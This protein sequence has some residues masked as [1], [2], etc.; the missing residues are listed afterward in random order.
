MNNLGCR[1]PGDVVC[2]PAAA[3]PPITFNYCVL[4][5]ENKNLWKKPTMTV[6]A[7][8]IA[9]ADVVAGTGVLVEFCNDNERLLKAAGLIQDKTPESNKNYHQLKYTPFLNPCILVAA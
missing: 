2:D 6:T 3:A 8:P 1:F 9:C 5:D 4:A 7:A